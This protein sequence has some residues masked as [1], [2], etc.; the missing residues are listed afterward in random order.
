MDTQAGSITLTVVRLRDAGGQATAILWEH[1][2]DRLLNLARLRL[3][4]RLRRSIDA[5]EPVV[6]ASEKFRRAVFEGK[7]PS[8]RD[9]DTLWG[10]LARNI[11]HKIIGH[12]R[13]ELGRGRKVGE[14]WIVAP[15]GDHPLGLDQFPDTSA[16]RDFA[17]LCADEFARLDDD[18]Q[19]QTADIWMDG[20]DRG[21]IADRLDC[22]VAQVDRL[23]GRDRT[24]WR[25]DLS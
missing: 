14:S 9:R 20:Y 10:V 23:P 13:A 6:C 3:A 15:S 8:V 21:E 22:S 5:E 19:R 2:S 12:A 18:K 7:L 17:A 1:F 25:E 11:R 24:I 16:A 4:S